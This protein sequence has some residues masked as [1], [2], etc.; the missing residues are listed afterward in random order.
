MNKS[1]QS[2]YHAGN[3]KSNNKSNLFTHKKHSQNEAVHSNFLNDEN[4][5]PNSRNRVSDKKTPFSHKKHGQSEIVHPSSSPLRGPAP[6]STF[7]VTAD[8]NASMDAADNENFLPVPADQER[9]SGSEYK[10]KFV[11]WENDPSSSHAADYNPDHGRYSSIHNFN[12]D[13]NT[14]NWE[15]ENH[16]SFKPL[17]NEKVQEETAIRPA[18]VATQRVNVKGNVVHHGGSD[19]NGIWNNYDYERSFP[20]SSSEVSFYLLFLRF[21]TLSSLFF[22]FLLFDCLFRKFFIRIQQNNWLHVMV[23]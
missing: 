1:L 5:H 22:L 9:R 8:V 7:R 21:L 19:E 12:V 15:S 6:P 14:A 17:L 13:M 2:S 4:Y 16:R 23:I 20:G 18:G 10:D 11:E 3:S